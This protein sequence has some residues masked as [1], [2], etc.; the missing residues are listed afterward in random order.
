M[1]IDVN[2]YVQQYMQNHH[3]L[4]TEHLR[5]NTKPQQMQN[6]FSKLFL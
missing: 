4:Y 1:S 6:N 2:K 5:V 3:I